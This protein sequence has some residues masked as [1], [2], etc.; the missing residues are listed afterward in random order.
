M[1]WFSVSFFDFL[2]V[3]LQAKTQQVQFQVSVDRFDKVAAHYSSRLSLYF[4]YIQTE[5][6]GIEVMSQGYHKANLILSLIS[7]PRA[8][9]GGAGV[10]GRGWVGCNMSAGFLENVPAN[11]V[12]RNLEKGLLKS[13]NSSGFEY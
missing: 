12:E 1:N 11:C 13:T 7:K 10:G 4:N 2:S 3:A 9:K 6:G 8:L 5:A